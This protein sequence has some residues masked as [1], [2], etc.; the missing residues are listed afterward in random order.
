MHQFVL[1]TALE[2]AGLGCN[3]QHYQSV[4]GVQHRAREMYQLPLDWD[5]RAQLVFG[6]VNEGGFPKEPLPKTKTEETV[7]VFGAKE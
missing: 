2:A 5:M 3:L 4:L 1:W 7:R 6:G